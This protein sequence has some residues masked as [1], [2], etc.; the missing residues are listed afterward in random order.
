[1]QP[2]GELFSR[3]SLLVKVNNRTQYIMQ[4]LKKQ[5]I[6]FLSTNLKKQ[7]AILCIEFYCFKM[8]AE[9]EICIQTSSN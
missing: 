5:L 8:M 1:M 9:K 7:N 4:A 2:C 6:N 3:T